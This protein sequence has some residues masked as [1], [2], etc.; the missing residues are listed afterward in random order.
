MSAIGSGQSAPQSV[1]FEHS[2]VTNAAMGLIAKYWRWL[3]VSAR[4]NF[5][6]KNVQNRIKSCY[7]DFAS[8][9]ISKEKFSEKGLKRPSNVTN[10]GVFIL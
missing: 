10:G 6:A 2:V 3:W 1:T 9:L 7:T 8:S 4:G 5:R